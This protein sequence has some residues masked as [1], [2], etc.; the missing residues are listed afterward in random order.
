MA[1]IVGIRAEDMEQV[2]ALQKARIDWPKGLPM[3]RP[4]VM[5]PVLVRR[6]KETL[7]VPARFGFTRKFGSFNAR[8]ENLSSSPF[9]RGMFGKSHGVFA[10]SYVVEW[11]TDATV[12]KQPYL[13]QRADGRLLFAPALVGPYKDKAGETGFALCTREPN[14]FVGFFHDRMVGL[15]T[16]DLMDRW[17]EPE[18]HDP[19]EL[20]ECVAAPPD[21][22]LVAVPASP[23]IQLR[24][25][26]DWSPLKSA[27]A[28]LRWADVQRLA[29]STA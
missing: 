14:R 28:P 23:D 24:K 11:V 27:G 21:D 20:L 2:D 5:A 7:H 1:G 12:G 8:S 17:L 9:W 10:F 22:E 4:H 26:G 13:I 25:K 29:R 3:I 6:G 15:C 19:K 16:P 18:G